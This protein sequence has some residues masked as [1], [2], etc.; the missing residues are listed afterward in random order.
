[1]TIDE[2][3]TLSPKMLAAV[4][5]LKSVVLDRYL[6]CVPMMA[7]VSA[8]KLALDSPPEPRRAGGAVSADRG[9]LSAD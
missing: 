5:Q 8:G 1:M 7:F 2:T 6:S 9:R 3:L 4:D